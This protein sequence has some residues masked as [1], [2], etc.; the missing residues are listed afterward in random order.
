MGGYEDDAAWKY[1]EDLFVGQQVAIHQR[2]FR[3]V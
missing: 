1:V 2:F 3:R